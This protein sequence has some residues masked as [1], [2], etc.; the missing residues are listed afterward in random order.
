MSRRFVP[1]IIACLACGPA[2]AGT[3]DVVSAT[4][5]CAGSTCDFTV[6]VRHDDQG[7][8]HYANA[9]EVLAPDGSLLAT[10]VLRHPHVS[11]QPFTRGLQG[12]EIPPE[13][14]S[15]RIRAR[16]SVHGFGGSEV[17]ID[18]DR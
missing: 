14:Q 13:I 5:D 11:E 6:T 18:L 17:E 7:W 10:R 15:V 16:D 9:W 8:S 4:A 1:S 2:A 3:A 12:V